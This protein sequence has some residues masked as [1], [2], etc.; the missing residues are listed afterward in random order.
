[1]QKPAL[2]IHNHEN[3]PRDV[4]RR[5]V[6]CHCSASTAGVK[7]P[8]HQIPGTLPV[9]E[10]KRSGTVILQ[11]LPSITVFTIF[12]EIVDV[13]VVHAK[14]GRG[15]FRLLPITEIRESSPYPGAQHIRRIF[16]RH[17][18]VQLE[19]VRQKQEANQDQRHQ[20]QQTH[21]PG[22]A[23]AFRL[24]RSRHHFRRRRFSSRQRC[25]QRISPL[26]RGCH[27][28]RRGRPLR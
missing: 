6:R 28:Q 9:P 20:R 16:Q 18:I 26:Q 8:G 2:R 11:R 15:I 14:T 13:I 23:Q 10:Q 1:M 22:R 24:S 25:G 17:Q 5:I 27:L 21:R 12:C 3:H 19:V 7:S 4:R